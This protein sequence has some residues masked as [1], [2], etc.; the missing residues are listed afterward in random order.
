MNQNRN[1]GFL[2]N[3]QC[4]NYNEDKI[5]L[6]KIKKNKALNKQLKEQS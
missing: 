6:N 2:L 4:S 1:S 3:F 5:N